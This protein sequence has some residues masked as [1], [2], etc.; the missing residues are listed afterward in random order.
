MDSSGIKE[1]MD[2][3]GSDSQH[4]GTVDELDGQRIKLTKS[5][6][7]SGGQHHFIGLDKVASVEG[8]KVKLSCTAQEA[9]A[10]WTT[11]AAGGM[12]S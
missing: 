8:G 7:A 5:D 1:H 10:G 3:V 6:P 11:E 2:V 4:V 9:R 12:A